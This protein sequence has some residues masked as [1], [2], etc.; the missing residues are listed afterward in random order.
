MFKRPHGACTYIDEWA[1]DSYGVDV[2]GELYVEILLPES[3]RQLVRSIS[4]RNWLAEI[5]QI[6]FRMASSISWKNLRTVFYP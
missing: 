2:R 6:T 3:I 4:L 5:P 1:F